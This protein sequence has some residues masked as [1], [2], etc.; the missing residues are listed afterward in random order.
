M[1]QNL[2]ALL[3]DDASARRF[4]AT[5]S[6]WAEFRHDAQNMCSR[7]VVD[8]GKRT[9]DTLPSGVRFSCQK[10]PSEKSVLAQTSLLGDTNKVF[11]MVIGILFSS[12]TIERIVSESTPRS[13][14]NDYFKDFHA[15]I[16]DAKLGTPET[17]ILPDAV[18]VA[19]E[20]IKLFSICSRHEVQMTN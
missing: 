18:I 11:L 13:V 17:G 3:T 8:E 6:E 14:A 2:C 20:R 16:E 9:K 12:S 4:V 1:N 10:S 7:V 5:V 15:R 19:H